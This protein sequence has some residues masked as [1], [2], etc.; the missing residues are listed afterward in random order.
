MTSH[1]QKNKAK[2]AIGT[3]TSKKVILI[4]YWLDIP[5]LESIKSHERGKRGR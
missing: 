1:D 2:I 4:I 3:E 5:V